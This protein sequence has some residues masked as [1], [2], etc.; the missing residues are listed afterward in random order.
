M[1]LTKMSNKLLINYHD[2]VIYSSD[3]A[4]LDNPTAWLNDACIHFWLTHLQKQQPQ[5]RKQ[6]RRRW[7]G[8]RNLNEPVEVKTEQLQDLFL[9]PYVHNATFVCLEE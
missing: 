9:D 6:E 3:L 8:E 2:A 7:R 4:L 5:H 1:N